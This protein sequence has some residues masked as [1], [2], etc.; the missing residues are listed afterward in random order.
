MDNTWIIRQTRDAN[1]HVSSALD[2]AS[3]YIYSHLS[4]RTAR[5]LVSGI[6]DFRARKKKTRKMRY[7]F[8]KSA[9]QKSADEKA[10]D[11]IVL[12]ESLSRG[13]S[14]LCRKEE[15]KRTDL[16]P[17][18]TV[19]KRIRRAVVP[20]GEERPTWD[21]GIDIRSV[22]GFRG[23][24]F[25]TR[26]WDGAMVYYGPSNSAT[27]RLRL[28]PPPCFYT[29]SFSLPSACPFPIVALSSVT[30]AFRSTPSLLRAH[31][32]PI[33]LSR[34]YRA[35]ARKIQPCFAAPYGPR[36][37]KVDPTG[38]H[39]F[40]RRATIGSDKVTYGEQRIAFL[41]ENTG[42]LRC[43]VVGPR[44]NSLAIL[45]VNGRCSW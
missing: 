10:G 19:Y 20:G 32:R 36:E 37:L 30:A 9:M 7:R 3:I 22:T 6:L 14:Q 5:P 33:Y 12:Y 40:G 42:N 44:S 26:P 1:I 8:L 31:V 25:P 24:I 15:T 34:L 17:A 4:L 13:R 41:R 2:L 18:S 35:G 45:L 21:V 16:Y 11:V 23:R 27:F 29:P 39:D 28:S 43:A 38:T